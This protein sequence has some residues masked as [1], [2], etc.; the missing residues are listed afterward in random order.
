MR[1][2]RPSA[3]SREASASTTPGMTPGS[4][5]IRLHGHIGS[6]AF[7]TV[8]HGKMGAEDVAVKRVTLDPQCMN[9]ELEIMQLLAE[10]RHG[11]VITLKHYDIQGTVCFFVME[12]YTCSLGDLIG[13][14]A[15]RRQGSPWKTKLYTYQLAR[16][17]AHIHGLDICH[18]DLKPQNVL[19]MP[20]TGKLVLCDFG[21]AACRLMNLGRHVNGL[22]QMIRR[23]DTYA[24]GHV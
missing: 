23:A 15:R 4:V 17:L 18:R 1:S 7:G 6:G 8:Y 24:A 13:E 16:A 5:E 10:K 3:T 12:R 20:A 22:R 9:R 21:K 11:N 19:V 14:W 2:K